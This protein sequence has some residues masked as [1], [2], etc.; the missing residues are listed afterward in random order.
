MSTRFSVARANRSVDDVVG[1]STLSGKNSIVFV[2]LSPRVSG[3]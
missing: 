1:M 3:M 2:V